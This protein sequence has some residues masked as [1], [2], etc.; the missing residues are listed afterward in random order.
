IYSS[1]TMSGRAILNPSADSNTAQPRDTPAS[2]GGVDELLERWYERL[3]PRI[4]GA[5]F[6][7][8]EGLTATL[9]ILGGL[10]YARLERLPLD[11]ALALAGLCALAGVSGG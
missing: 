1:R 3:R 7:A 5:F 10:T 2:L 6:V 8:L 11:Q 4:G 9:A